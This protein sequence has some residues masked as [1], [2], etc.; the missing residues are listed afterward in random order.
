M[1]VLAI[2]TAMREG[3]VAVVTQTSTLAAR[4]GDAARP[5]ATRL[6]G[7]AL[8][9]L[10]SAD[11]TLAD[12]SLFAVCLGPGAFTGLR[13]GIA[14]AQG[15]AFATALPIVGISAL[16]ALAL[17][18][19]DGQPDGVVAGV[20]MDAARGEVFAARYRRASE[21]PT[22]VALIDEPVSAHPDVVAARW[23]DDGPDVALWIGDG[24]ARHRTHLADDVRVRPA[25]ILAPLVGRLAI[26]R[27]SEAGAPHALRPLYVRPPDAELARRR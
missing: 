23:R 15:L 12:V 8:D 22:G 25:P 11:L 7:D 26:A 9:A 6:P 20:W 18:A 21:S 17:S 13:V 19:L 3:S 5:H 4:A 14:A 16:E 2:E 10:A 27:R 24:V 1:I